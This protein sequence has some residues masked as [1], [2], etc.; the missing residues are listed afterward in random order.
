MYWFGQI[1]P[2]FT[3]SGGIAEA[4]GV[5]ANWKASTAVIKYAPVEGYG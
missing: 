3:V 1:L 5:K 2:D 4:I